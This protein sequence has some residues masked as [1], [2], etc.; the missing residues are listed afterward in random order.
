[1]VTSTPTGL[2]RRKAQGQ[3]ADVFSAEVLEELEGNAAIGHVRYSTSGESSA[4]NVQPIYIDCKYGQMAVCHN[5]NLVNAHILRKDLVDSGY[6]PL[7][8]YDPTVTE[9]GKHP[10]KLD[11]RAP[12]LQ[13][14]EVA[15]KEAR[16]A[17]LARANPARAATLMAQAQEDIDER[18][19]MYEQFTEVD[20]AQYEDEEA[21]E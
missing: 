1:M 17:M 12:K 2:Q 9:E 4:L 20:W 16:Y 13:F 3:V 21:G 6:W 14:S 10:F 5:G 18:W 8:R 19:A 11:S 15:K 7:F